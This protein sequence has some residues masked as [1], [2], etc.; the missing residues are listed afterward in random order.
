MIEGF[1]DGRTLM[2]ADDRGGLTPVQLRGKQPEVPRARLVY[3]V[4]AVPEVRGCWLHL[5]DSRFR[6]LPSNLGAST[7]SNHRRRHADRVQPLPDPVGCV[8]GARG[9]AHPLSSKDASVKVNARMVIAV[10]WTI[11]R[12]RREEVAGFT[13]ARFERRRVEIGKRRIGPAMA[14]MSLIGQR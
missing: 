1:V 2:Q 3:S 14:K 13:D 9:T 8:V 6:V 11:R 5:Q 10:T 4:Q 7:A 12:T